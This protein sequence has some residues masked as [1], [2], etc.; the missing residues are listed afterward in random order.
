MC[1]EHCAVR[2]GNI[3]RAGGEMNVQ[4]FVCLFVCRDMTFHSTTDCACKYFL[5]AFFLVC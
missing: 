2:P 3:L 1:K 4:D 5:N